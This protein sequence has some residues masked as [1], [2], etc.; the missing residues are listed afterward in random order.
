[1]KSTTES[2]NQSISLSWNAYKKGIGSYGNFDG[3]HLLREAE[4]EYLDLLA[5]NKWNASSGNE[6]S[7][8]LV[9]LCWNCG[10]DGHLVRYCR[11]PKDEKAIEC[12]KNMGGGGRGHGHGGQGGGRGHGRSGR[13]G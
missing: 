13:G 6:E 12:R 4:K 10:K 7:Q 11:L 9:F 2:F 1:M 5:S 8:K 3:D